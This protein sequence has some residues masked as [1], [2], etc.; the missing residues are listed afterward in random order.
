MWKFQ[1]LRS[2]GMLDIYIMTDQPE[3]RAKCYSRS[4]ILAAF[5]LDNLSTV[6]CKCFNVDC[7]YMFLVQEDD[8][9]SMDYWMDENRE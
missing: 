5:K 4:E 7:G 2:C 6:L 9:F 3:E 8:Y 1:N